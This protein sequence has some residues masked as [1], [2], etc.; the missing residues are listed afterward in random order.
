M[1]AIPM[2][3][4]V[5]ITPGAYGQRQ[6]RSAANVPETVLTRT[7]CSPCQTSRTTCESAEN[8]D[9]PVFVTVS[10]STSAN[11]VLKAHEGIVQGTLTGSGINLDLNKV[12]VEVKRPW[13][14]LPPGRTPG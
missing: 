5:A 2:I 3:L 9:S 10:G 4:A 8:G 11:L 7:G 13:D 1:V 12:V 14:W 6:P